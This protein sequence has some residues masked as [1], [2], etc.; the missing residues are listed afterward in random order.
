MQ[1]LVV[2]DERRMAELL[3]KTLQ[4]EGHQVIVARDGREGFE[5]ARNSPFD[6]IVLDLMLPGMDGFS[7]A[8]KLRACRNQTPVLMLTAR[9][10]PADIVRGLDAG[11]DDY[12]TKPFSIEI[13]LARLRAVSRR[14]AIPRP[15]NLE[16]ADLKLDPA[17]RRV[18]R[19][20]KELSLTP[21][22]YRL[23]ELLMRNAGRAVGR[24]KILESVWGFA[25][26]VNENTLE[27]F[28]RLLRG[29]VDQRE[30]KLIQTVRGF[31]YMLRDP[32]AD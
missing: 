29:K 11:A 31:G 15:V 32:A 20:G 22:E 10:A 13:L 5:I 26:E 16:V 6:V 2:E 9:D 25:S 18:T 17:S 7:I 21:R 12:L 30:P 23:L 27:V 24:D 28:M 4:E 19:A 1:I 3:E 14:G 8:R